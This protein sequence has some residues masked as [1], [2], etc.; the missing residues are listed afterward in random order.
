MSER[1]VMHENFH[2]KHNVLTAPERE[3]ETRRE[4]ERDS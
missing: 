3:R 4:R 2:T 1:N